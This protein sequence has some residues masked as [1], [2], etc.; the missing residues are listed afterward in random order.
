M[1]KFILK[2]LGWSVSSLFFLVAIVNFPR[3]PYSSIAFIL[4]GAIACPPIWKLT[5]RYGNTWNIIGRLLVFMLSIIIAAQS[6]DSVNTVAANRESPSAP[7][8]PSEKPSYDTPSEVEE[9]PEQD[10]EPEASEPETNQASSDIQSN[11]RIISS[12]DLPGEWMLTVDSGELLCIPPKKVVFVAPD[13][14]EYGVNGTAKGFGYP[15]I[16]PIWKDNPAIEG[17]KVNI[18]PL[19][20]EGLKLCQ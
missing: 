5:K 19:I 11:R 6:A 9:T 18:G 10:T 4:W 17:T 2:F 3:I 12:S 15:E 13:G 1:V 14:T 16:T 7:S 8:S 20:E